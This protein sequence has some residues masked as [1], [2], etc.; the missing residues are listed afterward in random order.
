MNKWSLFTLIELLVVIAI[1]AILAAML[2]PALGS[3]RQKAK[4][5]A[6]AS[7]FKQLGAYFAIY[8]SN[9]NDVCPPAA[10]AEG[11]PNFDGYA[12]RL[13]NGAMGKKDENICRCPTVQQPG[14]YSGANNTF[15]TNEYN[16]R[17]GDTRSNYPMKKVG[18][19]YRP[20]TVKVI[21][22]WGIYAGSS[23]RLIYNTGNKADRFDFRTPQNKYIR[24][25]GG[26]NVLLAD[27]HVV[28]RKFP[29]DGTFANTFNGITFLVEE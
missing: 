4:M 17:L 13:W 23:S 26:T 2:L 21:S 6:C 27:F 8:A 12:E 29:A 22:C 16:R 14:Q 19:I 3:A 5:I 7:Q 9:Y 1:I 11:T 15:V 24:H 28:Y 20:T 10:T 18:T 25:Q